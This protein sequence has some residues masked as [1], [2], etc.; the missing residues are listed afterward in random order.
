MGE[1]NLFSQLFIF[2][3]SPFFPISTTLLVITVSK[4]KKKEKEI[5]GKKRL[6]IQ[7]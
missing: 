5:M 4:K 7:R 6:F 3:T 2:I 1:K